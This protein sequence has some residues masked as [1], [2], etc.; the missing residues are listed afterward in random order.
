MSN[1]LF[2]YLNGSD[3]GY[4]VRLNGFGLTSHADGTVGVGGIEFDDEAANLTVRGWM[5]IIIRELACT[6]APV[7]FSGFIADRNYSRIGEQATYTVGSSRFINTN[8][9]DQNALLG[10]RLITGTDGKRPAETDIQ[11]ID[12]LLDSAYLSGLV[13]DLGLVDRSN[14]RPFEEADY[15]GQYPY[16]VLNDVAAPIFRIFYV[17]NSQ[18]S[19]AR[20]LYYDTPGSTAATS[21]LTISNVLS[22]LSSTC[23]YPFNDATLNRDPSEVYDKVRF[24]YANGTVIETNLTTKATFFDDNNIYYRGLQVDNTRYGLESSARAAADRILVRDSTENDTIT[25]TIQLPPESVGLLDAGQRVGVR[26]LHFPGY[27]T[28]TYTR[29]TERTVK[30]TPNDDQLYDVTLT[31]TAHGLSGGGGGGAPGPGVFPNPPPSTP[32][33]EQQ[34]G[35]PNTV[36]LDTVPV[37]GDL[38]MMWVTMRTFASY[39]DTPSGWTVV[40]TAIIDPDPYHSGRL[41]TRIAS[42]ESGTYFNAAGTIVHVSEWT[43][44]TLGAS[45]HLNTQTGTTVSAGGPLT[46]AAGNAIVVGC[47]VYGGFN[48]GVIT[49]G[50]GVVEL[51]E[52]QSPGGLSPTNWVGYKIAVTPA[53]TTV[54][55]TMADVGWA[56]VTYVLESTTS[57]NP[58]E[59]GQWV[60]DETPTPAPGGGNRVFYTLFP[61]ASGS[62]QVFVD[63]IDQTAAVTESNPATG[64]FTLAFDPRSWEQ[65]LVTYQGR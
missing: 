24:T 16:D 44:A 47:G 41:F 35:A 3:V 49:P 42:G 51:Y 39:P 53:S 28:L 31:L 56:G 1:S 55:G 14:P 61:Y 21:T 15:R 65:I 25:C 10:V 37:D 6:S 43:G 12:W 23:F 8:C 22:D 52:E 2:A 62:L 20:G 32:T 30:Q 11:R 34:K 26:F 59:P 29:V 50:A 36:T 60:Y 7:L 48:P 64:Q 5:T 63:H 4:K 46:P 9:I 33:L 38:L 17:Y 54:D 27:E 18:P 57:A 19:G 40:D 58:P 45:A 13:T